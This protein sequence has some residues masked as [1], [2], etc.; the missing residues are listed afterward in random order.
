MVQK[1]RKK[2]QK[3]NGIGLIIG[4]VPMAIIGVIC[5]DIYVKNFSRSEIALL[6]AEIIDYPEYTNEILAEIALV[7][8]VGILF[9]TIGII[10]ALIG[11]TFL[12]LG[13]MRRTK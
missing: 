12:S 3:Q 7:T 10:L 6:Q 9:L 4:S 5:I 1:A 8:R 2:K 11:V 13:I